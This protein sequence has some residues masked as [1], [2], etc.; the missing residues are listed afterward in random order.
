MA[1]RSSEGSPWV[2]DA[3]VSR[4]GGPRRPGGVGQRGAKLRAGRR[5]RMEVG[6]ALGQDCAQLPSPAE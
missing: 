6:V 3:E 4:L 1:S 2:P 5:C